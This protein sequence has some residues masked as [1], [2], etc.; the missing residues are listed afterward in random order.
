MVEFI[1]MSTVDAKHSSARSN[2]AGRSRKGGASETVDIFYS[3]R[4]FRWHSCHGL[5]TSLHL[6]GV[7]SRLSRVR[8]A[9]NFLLGISVDF[10]WPLANI[11]G[12]PSEIY[13]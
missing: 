9:R 10:A 1:I 5:N 7:A 11:R 8:G 6:L 12:A 4:H 13:S 2:S 3:K